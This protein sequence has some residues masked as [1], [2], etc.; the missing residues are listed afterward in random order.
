VTL[1]ILLIGTV[2]WVGARTFVPALAIGPIVAPPD[3]CGNQRP[4]TRAN[5]HF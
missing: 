4:Q 2:C 5:S 3:D 1:V